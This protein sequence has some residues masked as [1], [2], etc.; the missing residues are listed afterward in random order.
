MHPLENGWHGGKKA[1]GEEHLTGSVVEHL[2]SAQGMI[3]GSWD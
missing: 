2:T 1:E 3:P